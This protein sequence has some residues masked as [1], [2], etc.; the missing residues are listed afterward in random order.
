MSNEIITIGDV[1]GYIDSNGVAQ[2]NA[3]DI[4]RGWGFTKSETK[5]GKVYDSVRWSRVNGYLQE[6]GFRPLVGEDDFIPENMAYRLGFKASND[7]AQVFQ[8]K[9]ADEILPAIRKHG[10]YLTPEKV[11]EVLLN[12]D[13]IITLAT[14][15]KA[16]QEKRKAAELKIEA[17]RPKVVFADSVSVS[18]TNIL[19]SELAK[20]LKQNGVPNMGQNRLFQWLRDNNYLISRRGT[21]YNMPMQKSMEMGLFCVKETT[22]NHSDGHTSISRTPKVT[23]KG[24]IYFVNKFLNSAK[25]LAED[26]V[27]N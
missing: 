16:E 24:Q 22:I 8:A 12:P 27:S 23:G 18:H 3:E 9:L 13:T 20:V 11:E 1:R 17:D 5:N 7:A 15:L 19:I 10:G 2:L 6:F 14:N 25:A 26:G 21:D 4:A